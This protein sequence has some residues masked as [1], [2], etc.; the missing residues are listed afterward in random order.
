MHFLGHMV[1]GAGITPT[2]DKVKAIREF[3]RPQ[4]IGQLMRFNGMI[5]FYGR[6][7]PRVAAMMAP[8]Y[9]ATKGAANKSSLSKMVV[10]TDTMAVA[11]KA[12]K[13]ALAKAAR[14]VHFDP[15][16]RLAL[17]TDEFDFM[18]GAV[19]EQNVNGLWQ[20]LAFFREHFQRNKRS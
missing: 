12:T 5:N 7:I 19:L 2:E 10:W 14:L 8:L 17:T 16:S 4:N 1:D 18:V 9:D 13:S 3:P 20:P 6:F 15:E 11:F